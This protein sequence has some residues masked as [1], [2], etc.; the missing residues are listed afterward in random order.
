VAD[1]DPS[2]HILLPNTANS[3]LGNWTLL[4]KTGEYV[5]FNTEKW[6]SDPTALFEVTSDGSVRYGTYKPSIIIFDAPDNVVIDFGCNIVSGF[7]SKINPAEVAFIRWNSNE[8]GWS[9]NGSY[10]GILE[11]DSSGN[12]FVRFADMPKTSK[13]NFTAHLK[14]GTTV[15]WMNVAEWN[16]SGNV[17]IDL[18]SG[19]IE[20][21]T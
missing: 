13:G 7:V 9:P 3:D 1:F 14:D 19:Q 15:V 18:G 2:G 20:Y 5:W 10:Q 16:T 4:L 6:E 11:A 21:R 17:T 12:Y 8:T